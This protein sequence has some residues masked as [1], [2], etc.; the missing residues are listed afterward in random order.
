MPR[1]PKKDPAAVALGRKGG[2]KRVPKGFSMMT[3]E[4]RAEIAKQAAAK[5]WG[6]KTDE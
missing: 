1:K 5:R 6:K 4:R 3:P 2:S